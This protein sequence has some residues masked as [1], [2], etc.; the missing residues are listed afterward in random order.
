VWWWWWWWCLLAGVQLRRH[1]VAQAQV[2]EDGSEVVAVTVD[3]EGAVLLGVQSMPPAEH[4][5]QEGPGPPSK[6]GPRGLEGPPAD[7]EGD[8]RRL[9]LVDLV[10]HTLLLVQL[11]ELRGSL[12][13]RLLPLPCE[14][15]FAL[16]RLALKLGPLRLERGG[17]AAEPFRLR[18]QRTR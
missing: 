13:Q 3:E 14:I 2:L 11:L 9:R 4:H 8:S 12:G 18:G 7:V 5:F 6:R 17:L 10:H 15:G 16:L 1:L